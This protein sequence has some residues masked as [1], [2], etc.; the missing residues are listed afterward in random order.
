MGNIRGDM[1]KYHL[2]ALIEK[3]K[4]EINVHDQK[5]AQNS[6]H[7]DCLPRMQKTL[8]SLQDELVKVE[9]EKLVSA[10]SNK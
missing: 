1:D 2:L 3:L 7:K 4:T 10:E 8:T 6:A 9:S 5:F